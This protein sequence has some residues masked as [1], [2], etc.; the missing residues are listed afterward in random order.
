[1]LLKAQFCLN[2]VCEMN[3]QSSVR[4]ARVQLGLEMS[5][6][7]GVTFHAC[8]YFTHFKNSFTNSWNSHDKLN[9]GV[10]PANYYDNEGSCIECD[11]DHR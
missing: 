8:F 1:M 5:Q 6:C 3:K 11:H 9:F 2:I 7:F 4:E 10:Q